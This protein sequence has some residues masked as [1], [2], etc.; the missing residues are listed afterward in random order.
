LYGGGGGGAVTGGA[1]GGGIIVFT[2]N[3]APTT[4][5]ATRLTNTGNLFVNGSFD[6]NTSIAPAKFRTTANT[7]YAASF[8][9]VTIAGGTVARRQLSDGTLPIKG[10]FDEVTGIS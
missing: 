7:V 8:D 3:T 6:E 1:G 10:T 9:E 4:T 5:L 2:Y